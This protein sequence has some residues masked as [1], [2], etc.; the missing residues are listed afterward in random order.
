MNLIT[1]I[2]ILSFAILV[3]A[4]L[5]LNRQRSQIYR[6]QE[7][8]PRH[9]EGLFAERNEAE[10]RFFEQ[11]QARLSAEEDRDKL[12]KRASEGDLFTLDV[13]HAKADVDLYREVL[14]RLV[15][16]TGGD[17]ERLR[18]LAEYVV[19]GKGLRSSASF[20]RLFIE[21]WGDT[22]D[23][24]SLHY[25][26]CLSALSDDEPTYL[27]AVDTALK[28][29]RFGRLKLGSSKDLLAIIECSYWLISPEIRASGTGFVVQQTISGVRRELAA[30]DR[31]SF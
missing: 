15:A 20:S 17:A 2:S 28:Q 3:V 7:L 16:Q 4:L 30:A 10:M 27:K 18:C 8:S 31:R 23:R 9:F 5:K 26:L 25:M 6:S 14:N 22:L 12:L 21:L 1:F 29:W 13:S 24:R 11:T 19:D